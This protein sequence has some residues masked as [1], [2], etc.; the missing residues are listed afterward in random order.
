MVWWF[1]AL[2]ISLLV[3]GCCGCC[4]FVCTCMCCYLGAAG[5]LWP[6][7]FGFLG[8]WLHALSTD[9]LLFLVLGWWG[10]CVSLVC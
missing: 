6:T 2:R 7:V 3:K 5:V 10:L 4:G 8:L 9:C 1:W